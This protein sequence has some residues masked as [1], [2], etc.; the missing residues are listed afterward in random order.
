MTA[1]TQRS[2]GRF[3]FASLRLRGRIKD[4]LRKPVSEAAHLKSGR[5]GEQ[6]AARLLK[7]KGWKIVGERVRVGK[8]D[9]IDIIA[10]DAPALVFVEVKTRKNE[11]YGR[12]FSAVNTEKK[13]RLSRAAVAYLKKK[14][15]KPDYIRFDVVEVIGEPDGD[16]PEIRHIENAFQL[17]SSYKLWW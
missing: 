1:K 9:E 15:I 7:S 6:Q 17:N 5:W 8:H 13:K 14:K 4:L 12:P 3:F 10:E 11:T 16:A 2:K